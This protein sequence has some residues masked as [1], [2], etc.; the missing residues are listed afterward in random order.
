VSD[1]VV[2]KEAGAEA[3]NCSGA[4]IGLVAGQ[5]LGMLLGH[6]AQRVVG[7]IAEV[8][9]L[10]DGFD[11]DVCPAGVGEHSAGTGGIGERE[12]PWAGVGRAWSFPI[13]DQSVADAV[14]ELV[15]LEALPDQHG[16][17]P[18]W[19]QGRRSTGLSDW[20]VVHRHVHHEIYMSVVNSRSK[21]PGV[22]LAVRDVVD[23]LRAH[24]QGCSFMIEQS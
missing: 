3:F 11:L 23:K 2:I 14:Q 17:P 16:K 6:M 24:H 19:G 12:R 21:S 15:A 10:F 8:H 9:G 13:R 18:T 7:I 22:D 1:P 5:Q 4:H 20:Q